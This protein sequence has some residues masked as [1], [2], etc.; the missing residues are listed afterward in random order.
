MRAGQNWFL[1][2]DR[3][4]IPLICTCS[5][6][7]VGNVS[8]PHHAG[9]HAD[10]SYLHML[11]PFTFQFVHV[12]NPGHF[13]TIYVAVTGLSC[14]DHRLRRGHKQDYSSVGL[15]CAFGVAQDLRKIEKCSNKEQIERR[16]PSCKPEPRKDYDEAQH[17]RGH[18]R[19][20]PI[21]DQPVP[22]VS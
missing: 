21:R 13:P 8:K 17:R 1:L 15:F 11:E 4:I 7:K 5:S 12:T 19:W 10:A 22:C 3:G 2:C 16:D 20:T 6:W 14:Q 9:K 18:K